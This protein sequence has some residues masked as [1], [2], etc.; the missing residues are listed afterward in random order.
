MLEQLSPLP[1]TAP[2]PPGFILRAPTLDD[3]PSAVAMF[4]AASLDLVG[5]S[6]FTEE[7][8]AA[9]WQE[10]GFT[11]A[12]DARVIVTAENQ[13]VGAT[14]VLF[15]PPYV[16]NFIWAR[17]HPDYRGRGFGTLLTQWAEGR[18][19][20]R[21]LEAPADARITA[22]CQSIAGHH[23]AADLLATLGYH[24]VRSFYSMKFEMASPPPLPQW[25]AG[26]TIRTMVPGQDE[27]ALYRAKDEAFRDHWGYV[28]SPFAE[29]FANWMHHIQHSPN[30]DPTLFFMAM[31]QDETGAAQVAG[32]AICQPTTTDYPDMGW[33]DS[34]GVR[35][36][37]R[38][39]GLALALLH[40][41]FG[42]FY[43][44]GRKKVGLGVDA[45][46]LTGAT[47]LYERAGMVPFRQ[48][49]TYEKELRPGRDLTTQTAAV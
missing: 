2:L 45:S 37:W 13:V 3:V 27:A 49:M 22:G 28:E 26:I 30:H 36:P 11:L 8:F 29:G 12:T 42:E 19:R 24:H 1:L 10:P 40:H 7:E 48:Y 47:R 38:R 35:R 46:S 31:G 23:A 44:R 33:V 14:D 16:R 20:E 17:V 18:I 6:Q 25:P 21:I 34:L 43:R 15:R 5:T 41:I 39:Q 9:D 32:Y 4:N